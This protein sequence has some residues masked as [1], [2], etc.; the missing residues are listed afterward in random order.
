MADLKIKN[1]DPRLVAALDEIVKQKQ[2]ADRS[3][4]MRDVLEKYVLFGDKYYTKEL[5]ETI[6]SLLHDSLN[7]YPEKLSKLL[8]YTLELVNENTRLL[9]KIEQLFGDENALL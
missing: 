2:Y 9:H 1:A 3:E 8:Q 5:P 6:K 7:E 4:L